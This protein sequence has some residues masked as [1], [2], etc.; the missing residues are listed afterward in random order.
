MVNDETLCSMRNLTD[1]VIDNK[2]ENLFDD[3]LKVRKWQDA[4]S[5]AFGICPRCNKE[6]M[7][8]IIQWKNVYIV[9]LS[10]KIL[11]NIVAQ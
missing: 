9:I 4:D 5:V 3:A 2:I 6:S 10:Q 1:Y 11:R 7:E 8:N